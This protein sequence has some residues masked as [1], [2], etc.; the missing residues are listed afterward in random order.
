MIEFSEFAPDQPAYQSSV[1]PLVQNVLPETARSYGPMP[2]LQAYSGALGA[3]AQGAMFVRAADATANGFAG[4][5]TKLYRLTA[6]GTSWADVSKGGGYTTNPEEKWSFAWYGAMAVATNYT[7]AIQA[8]TVGTSA[9]FADLA[10]A[11]PKA[12][13]C[14]TVREWVMVANTF[15]GTDGA[16]PQ[17]VW[18]PAIGDPTNWPTPGSVTAAQLQSDYQNLPGDGGWIQGLAPSLS[19]CDVAILQEHRVYR[20]AYVGP[21][22]IFTFQ[23][24]EGARGCPAPGSIVTFGPV[25]YYLGEDGFYAFDGAQSV[26]IGFGKVDRYFLSR[27]DSAY[28][29]RITATVDPIRKIIYWSYPGPQSSGGTPNYILAYCIP[30]QRW[31]EIA[32]ETEILCQS[33][34]FGY[35]LD[36]LDPFGTLETLPFSLDSRVWTGTGR[37]LLSAFDTT[38]KMG[39]FS[40]SNMAA[41]LDTAEVQATPNARSIVSGVRPIDDAASVGTISCGTRTLLSDASVFSTGVSPNILGNCPLRSE[42]LFHRFRRSIPAG[43]SWRQAQGVEATVRA[44][45][46]R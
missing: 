19:A 38:H 44:S 32:V 16:Q 21:P 23:P 25:C 17:R 11:A 28:M 45:G 41:T 31:A 15:D 43:A 29:Y 46:Y 35:T 2:S 20:A 12:R 3:R 18:W 4:D 42:G 5:A 24:A 37:P 9:L 26:P 27:V 13:H 10:A 30:L 34:A 1:S 40:G 36:Q 22:D 14:A 39:I 8:Y 33:A 7:N 6:A